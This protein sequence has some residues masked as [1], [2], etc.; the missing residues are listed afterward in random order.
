MN[1]FRGA[2]YQ[3]F[4]NATGKE[5][6][7]Y[8]DMNLSAQDHQNLFTCEADTGKPEYEIMMVAWRERDPNLRVERMLKRA[9]KAADVN[10]KKC[11]SSQNFSSPAEEA[12]HKRDTNVLIYI[13]RRLAMCARRLGKLKEAV[14]AMR[15]LIKEFPMLNVM[16]IHENLIEALLAMQAYADAQAVLARYDEFSLPKS[17]TICYTAALLKARIVSER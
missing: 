6:L 1:F 14:K 16:N 15:D 13:R 8:Y 11:H 3:R 17:A 2:E 9:L 4:S 10:Y 5:P 7:T 12:L